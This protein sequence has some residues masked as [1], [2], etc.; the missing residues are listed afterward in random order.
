MPK[1]R[2]LKNRRRFWQN[3]TQPRRHWLGELTNVAGFLLFRIA[4]KS[5]RGSGVQKSIA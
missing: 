2:V 1:V 4:W 3:K 5:D